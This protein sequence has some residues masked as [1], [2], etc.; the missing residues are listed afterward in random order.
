MPLG[1]RPFYLDIV[2]GYRVLL[3][4]QPFNWQIKFKTL[5]LKKL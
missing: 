2:G 5:L 1:H 3:K 4:K